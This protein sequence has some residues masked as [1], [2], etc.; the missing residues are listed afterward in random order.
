L[1]LAEALAH[2]DAGAVVIDTRDPNDFAAGHLKG[3][4]NVGLAGWYAEFVGGVI[5]DALLIPLT[6][7]NEQ[8][9]ALEGSK[10]TVSYCAVGFRSSIA[11]SRM[12]EAGFGDVSD[13]LGGY[14]AWT[15]ARSVVLVS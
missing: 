10:P 15:A 11:V 5:E 1:N 14:N 2:C 3:S 9:D 6:R 7:L 13:L 8:L 12:K 4:V